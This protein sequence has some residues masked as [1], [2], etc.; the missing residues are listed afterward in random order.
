MDIIV[1]CLH[2]LETFEESG[3]MVKRSVY[4]DAC[5][6]CK[7][8]EVRHRI[9][10]CQVH[11]GVFVVCREVERVIVGIHH[12]SNIVHVPKTVVW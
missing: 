8:E 12:T 4:D 7:G 10:D 3:P 11:W 6:E 2:T 1:L 9:V 5:C